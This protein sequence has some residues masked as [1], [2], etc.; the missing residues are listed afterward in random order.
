M[1]LRNMI[2]RPA[3]IPHKK[4]L[5]NQHV[6]PHDARTFKTM[7]LRQ[8]PLTTTYDILSLRKST[9]LTADIILWCTMNLV[10]N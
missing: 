6:S 4:C 3:L 10:T 8:Q 5:L 2:K 9:R 1:V 7:I